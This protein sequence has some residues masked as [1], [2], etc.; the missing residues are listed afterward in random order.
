MKHWH[1]DSPEN[2]FAH[3][4]IEVPCKNCSTKWCE[5]VDLFEYDILK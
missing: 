5:P 4:S 2:W 1:G 3:I